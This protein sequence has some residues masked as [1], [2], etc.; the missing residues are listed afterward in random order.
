M[1]HG[2][3][4]AWSEWLVFVI[5]KVLRVRGGLMCVGQDQAEAVH[6]QQLPNCMLEE[7]AMERLTEE[8]EVKELTCW[9]RKRER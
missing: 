7:V 4:H 5:G 6:G 3:H 8:E 9:R 1:H 2:R